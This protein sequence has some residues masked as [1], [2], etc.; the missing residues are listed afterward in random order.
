MTLLV[1]Y[2]THHGQAAR[3]AQ[4]IAN[5]AGGAA[6]GDVRNT[7]AAQLDH[8][9]AVVIVAS[10]QIGKH[11]RAVTRFV[12]RNRERLNAVRSA[13]VSVSGAAIEVATRGEAARMAAGFLRV[14]GWTPAEQLLAGGAFPFTKYNPL[15]RFFLHR[16]F[17]S[18]GRKLDPHRDYDFTDWDAVTQFARAFAAHEEN[19]SVE[20]AGGARV[21][22]PL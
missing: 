9:D 22:V 14:T 6:A 3:I 7:P 18:K 10:V 8:T 13:F 4:H 2:S 21:R 16:M 5:T 20:I 15:L 1:L 17:A 12:K 11:S 19:N